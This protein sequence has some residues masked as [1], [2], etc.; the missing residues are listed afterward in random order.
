MSKRT[1][2]EL[3]PVLVDREKLRIFSAGALRH[4]QTGSTLARSA[5]AVLALLLTPAL[6]A[7]GFTPLYA[8]PGVVHGLSHI[9]VEV[10]QTRT[11]YL[12]REDLQDNLALHG[13]DEKPEYR[14]VVD[15]NEIRMARGLRP[16]ATADR[17]ETRLRMNYTLTRIAT[18]EV[19][20]KRSS[21]VSVVTPATAQPYAGIAGQQAAQ[22]RAAWGA[23]QFIKTQILR[24]LAAR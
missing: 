7:C 15:L 1:V 6:N 14:L 8:D 21:T 10:P 4:R 11:G 3:S 17:Y 16:D 23:S 5:L 18:G 24:A 22:E 20:L 2:P 13:G 9:Q 19:V 12:I